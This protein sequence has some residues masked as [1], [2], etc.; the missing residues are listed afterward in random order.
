MP[1]ARANIKNTRRSTAVPIDVDED[2]EFA[3]CM[4][5]RRRDPD[6]TDIAVSWVQCGYC[7]EWFHQVCVKFKSP[8]DPDASS[9]F[10]CTDCRRYVG[11][12]KYFKEAIAEE[13]AGVRREVSELREWT[14][15]ELTSL[16]DNVSANSEKINTIV[17][18]GPDQ[19][20][21]SRLNLVE[22]DV[23]RRDCLYV[24]TLSGLPVLEGSNDI[25]VIKKLGQILEVNVQ[26][27]DISRC[28]R[29]R[30][31][32]PNR[33]PLLYCRF[34]DLRIKNSFY[35][36][37]MRKKNITLNLVKEGCPAT[38]IYINELLSSPA[39]AVFRAAKNLLKEKRVAAV[40]TVDGHVM[41][42]K[43]GTNTGRRVMSTDELY[44]LVGQD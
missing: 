42:K 2:E 4:A 35:H 39:F 29:A 12:K 27:D 18:K 19:A 17:T 6:G 15:R 5:C 37:W 43:A 40:Y 16:S 9:A 7:E 41:V 38:R 11:L 10:C 34:I 28:W 26:R 24:V 8:S 1:K 22:Q 32:D 25:D 33:V 13:I 30:V 3:L 14:E 31:N 21:Q 36:A 23:M 20:T 44:A